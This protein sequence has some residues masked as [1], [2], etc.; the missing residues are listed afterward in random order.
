[1]TRPCPTLRLRKFHILTAAVAFVGMNGIA[2]VALAAPA[3]PEKPVTLVVPYGPTSDTA[4]YTRLIIS[5]VAKTMPGVS[6][7]EDY[8]PGDSGA[9]A[10]SEVKRAPADGYTLLVGRVGSQVISPALKPELPYRWN[11]FSFIGLIEIDPLLC[12]VRADSPYKTA[13]DLM[14]A[15]RA[16][17]GALNMVIRDREPSRTPVPNI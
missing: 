8:R 14:H 12:A 7:V 17:P 2:A 15:V 6:F 5:H 9:K 11:D 3:Y 4:G 16:A 13:R 1:M 10:A